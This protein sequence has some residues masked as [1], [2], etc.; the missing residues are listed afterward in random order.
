MG[1]C[2]V[3]GQRLRPTVI[4]YG[5]FPHDDDSFYLLW[6]K[7]QLIKLSQALKGSLSDDPIMIQVSSSLNFFFNST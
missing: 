7:Q 5:K 6:Q 4:R 3:R 2:G 1:S